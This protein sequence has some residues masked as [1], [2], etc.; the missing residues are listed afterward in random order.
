MSAQATTVNLAQ[1]ERGMT[2]DEYVK[3][4]SVPRAPDKDDDPDAVAQ[5]LARGTVSEFMAA[6]KASAADLRR[7]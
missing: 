7:R 1:G 2:Y 6:I 4:F 3:K 5:K